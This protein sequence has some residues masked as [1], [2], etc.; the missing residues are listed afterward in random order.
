MRMNDL[1][2]AVPALLSRSLAVLT[3]LLLAGSLQA[4][5]SPD[6]G[7]A[8]AS[9]ERINQYVFDGSVRIDQAVSGDLI[10]AGGDVE[11]RAPVA[12]DAYVMGGDVRVQARIG[13]S[14]FATGGNVNVDAP[15]GRHL[16]A[17]GGDLELGTAGR[18]GGDVTVGGGEVILRG[19]VDG[20]VTV[21]G[22]QVLIDSVIGG[23]VDASGGQLRLGPNARV[24]GSV[25]YRS[26]A[27]LTQD[28]GSQ[29]LGGIQSL[30][31]SDGGRPRDAG[32]GQS[33]VAWGIARVVGAVLL[34]FI[35]ALVTAGASQ[36]AARLG[37]HVQDRPGNCLLWG[38]AIIVG[39]PLAA[40][41]LFITVIGIPLGLAVLVLYPL[42]LLLG[43]LAGVLAMAHLMLHAVR[44]DPPPSTGWRVLAALVAVLLLYLLWRVPVAGA[45]LSGL[46][47][48]LGTGSI[49]GLFRPRRAA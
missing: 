13:E 39:L 10:A 3:A 29:V 44:P 21:G 5:T 8:P 15:V 32:P 9:T 1:D 41:L 34:A 38:L 40:T 37:H 42:L 23:D 36:L 2:P 45:L 28:P 25:R 35:A 6:A 12:G 47:G 14:L 24:A 49:V 48:L 30:G 27:E 19:A 4:Q 46:V 22:G 7:P 17:G 11:V 31:W 33:D 26:G 20:S 43:Y 16:R 18:V